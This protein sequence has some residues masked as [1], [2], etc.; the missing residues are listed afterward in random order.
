MRLNHIATISRTCWD[1]MQH[2]NNPPSAGTAGVR[3]SSSTTG[4]KYSA[5]DDE[6]KPHLYNVDKVIGYCGARQ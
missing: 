6:L 2:D 3:Y 1:T 4:V 5:E